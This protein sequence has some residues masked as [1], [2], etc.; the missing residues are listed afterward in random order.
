MNK[1][2]GALLLAIAIITVFN[3][4]S[5]KKYED[6]PSFSLRSKTAR[7]TGEWELIAI[8]DSIANYFSEFKFEKNGDFTFTW[9]DGGRIGFN[10]DWEF[11]DKKENITTNFTALGQLQENNYKINRLTNKELW[12]EDASNELWKLEKL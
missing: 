12:M 6:G 5:C 7:L 11:D 2:I 10:G 4:H 3:F 9:T 1:K 8:G